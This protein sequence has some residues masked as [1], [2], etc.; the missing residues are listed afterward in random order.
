MSDPVP[1][2]SRA[3]RVAPPPDWM[4]KP[5][6]KITRYALEDLRDFFTRRSWLHGKSGWS[7]LSDDEY[8]ALKGR[9][10]RLPP[11]RLNWLR[12]FAAGWR[13]AK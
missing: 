1:E 9:S 10:L 13:S 8:S 12:G 5:A 7:L 3:G 2:A 4:T 11:K 6:K